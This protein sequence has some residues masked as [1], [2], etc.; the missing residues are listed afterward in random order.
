MPLFEAQAEICDGTCCVYTFTLHADLP[1]A[2]VSDYDNDCDGVRNDGLADCPENPEA[3]SCGAPC[4]AVQLAGVTVCEQ[5]VIVCDHLQDSGNC[6]CPCD[7]SNTQ[8][9]YGFEIPASQC[10][11][12]IECRE[13]RPGIYT[14][15]GV[16]R[17]TPEVCDD[18]TICVVILRM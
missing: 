6:V 12:G 1:S 3:P 14:L 11:A 16:N 15:D 10:G 9:D 18:G 17:Q 7:P 5:G 4:G 2:F 8:P 13:Y